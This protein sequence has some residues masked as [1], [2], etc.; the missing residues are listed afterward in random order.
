MATLIEAATRAMDLY[1][2]NYAPNDKFL[3][4]DD[5]KYQIATTY[6]T[7][8]N[9]LYQSQHKM[10]KQS[11]GFA[12]IE[13]PAAWLV[14][15]DKLIVKYDSENDRYF[16]TLSYPVFSFDFDNAANGLMGLHKRGKGAH[17][18]YRK[19]SLNERRFREIIPPAGVVFFYLNTPT[20]I[21]FWGAK[22]GALPEGQYVPRVTEQENDCMLS[23]NII[24][25]LIP[26]VLDVMFRSKNG[27]FIQKI[28]DQNP[29]VN[30]AQQDNPSVRTA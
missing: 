3:D 26:V 2:Q 27:N 18:V 1:Y 7:I 25:T 28:D 13:I 22:E 20:E 21:V 15:D 16:T 30:P 24:S 29:N 11:E 10:N 19:I 6:C 5:F 12:N 4:I 17:C 14:T 8:L 23:D 9:G